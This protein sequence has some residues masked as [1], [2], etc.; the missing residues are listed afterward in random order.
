ME[1]CFCNPRFGKQF[2]HVREMI[3]ANNI[4]EQKLDSSICLPTTSTQNIVLR[5]SWITEQNTDSKMIYANNILEQKFCFS[6]NSE[7]QSYFFN[8]TITLEISKQ[9]R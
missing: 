4:L 5:N 3:Y 2:I 1:L 6:K 7:K 8:T 9:Q